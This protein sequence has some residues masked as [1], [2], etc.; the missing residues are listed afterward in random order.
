MENKSPI[1]NTIFFASDILSTF[2]EGNVLAVQ[3]LTRAQGALVSAP[4]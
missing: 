3:R 1:L 4:I 2:G